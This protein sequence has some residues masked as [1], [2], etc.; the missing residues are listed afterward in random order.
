MLLRPALLYV[1]GLEISHL[2]GAERTRF[3]HVE[4]FAFWTQPRHWALLGSVAPRLLRIEG[5]EQKQAQTV[6]CF[7][8]GAIGL[9]RMNQE[10]AGGSQTNNG[11][12]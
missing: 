4:F 12:D 2:A 10:N 6:P 8:T 1:R 5:A 11:H 9:D 3:A 7:L